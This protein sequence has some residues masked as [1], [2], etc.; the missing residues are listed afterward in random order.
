MLVYSSLHAKMST[1][2]IS[3]V[4]SGTS[5]QL[6]GLTDGYF[7]SICGMWLGRGQV[8]DH[9]ISKKHRRNVTGDQPH[10]GTASR[11]ASSSEPAVQAGQGPG[12]RVALLSLAGEEV[13]AII[14]APDSGWREVAVEVRLQ[15]HFQAMPPADVRAATGASMAAEGVQVIRR[16]DIDSRA[17]S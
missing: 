8:K 2:E 13:G 9:L 17:L 6:G 3:L 12:V 15:T 14:V 10:I 7:C 11:P 1:D 16:P 4:A 5:G